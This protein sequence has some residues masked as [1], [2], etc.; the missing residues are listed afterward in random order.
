MILSYVLKKHDLRRTCHLM[1]SQ[2][3]THCRFFFIKNWY[4]TSGCAPL[5]SPLKS[6][7]SPNLSNLDQTGRTLGTWQLAAF[8]SVGGTL[9]AGKR[10]MK[11]YPFDGIYHERWGFLTISK[12]IYP[13]EHQQFAPENRPKPTRKQS[14]S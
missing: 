5:W 6:P 10:P 7:P 11:S 14:Y 4:L 8:A 9:S 13:P 3:M 12:H 2:K 1:Y